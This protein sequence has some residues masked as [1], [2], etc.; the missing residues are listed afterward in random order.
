MKMTR[1]MRQTHQ[2]LGLLVGIQVFLWI[3]G[4]FVMS[5]LPLAKVRGE[6]RIAARAPIPV[7]PA[8][9]LV[10]PGSIARRAAG[11]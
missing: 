7:D 1:I 11:P 8:E 4:G 6:D 3:S 5:A 10:S 2:G 9:N